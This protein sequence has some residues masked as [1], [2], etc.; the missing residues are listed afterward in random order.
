[1]FF[2][3]YMG[4]PEASFFAYYTIG[5]SLRSVSLHTIW[6]SLHVSLDLRIPHG[7]PQVCLFAYYMSPLDQFIC[8]LNP[9]EKF[10]ALKFP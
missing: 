3:Y 10:Y 9:S 1:M 7:T 4:V 8:I 5:G 2:A 6:E